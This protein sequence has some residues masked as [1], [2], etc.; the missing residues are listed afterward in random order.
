MNAGLGIWGDCRR[1]TSLITYITL[2]SAAPCSA[3]YER[4]HRLPEAAAGSIRACCLIR[5]R[6][7]EQP[8][9]FRAEAED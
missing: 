8:Q 4:G 2:R 6:R 5:Q 1:C 7:Q 3:I 9:A